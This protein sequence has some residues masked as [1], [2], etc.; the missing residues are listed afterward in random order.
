MFTQILDAFK[1]SWDEFSS[2][3][4]EKSR[5]KLELEKKAA[6]KAKLDLKRELAKKKRQAKKLK[7]GWNPWIKDF[8]S[9]MACLE[10]SNKSPVSCVRV[11]K[12]TEFIVSSSHDSTIKVWMPV[13]NTRGKKEKWSCC[14]VL[15]GH[16]AEVINI[17]L[18]ERYIVSGSWD[19]TVRVWRTPAQPKRSPRH[20]H[21]L[22]G[23]EE[24][25]TKRE[26]SR[27]NLLW[28]TFTGHTRRVISVAFCKKGEMIASADWGGN[29][30]VWMRS[31]K[32]LLHT[33]SGG[34]KGMVMCLDFSP[35]GCM[36]KFE[37]R[38]GVRSESHH[39]SKLYQRETS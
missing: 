13:Q 3:Q 21:F 38:T 11:A 12:N 29:V 30:R 25:D 17:D 36:E 27:K 23:D 26:K 34:H 39:H 5:K 35:N 4:S 28:H 24:E 22:A 16:T 8:G 6:R 33:F 7:R 14:Y 31:S 9:E 37:I 20:T 15:S 32:S 2:K 1:D 19:T 10:N 18:S